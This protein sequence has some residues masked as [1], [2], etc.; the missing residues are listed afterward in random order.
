MTG[1]IL[2]CLLRVICFVLIRECFI[3]MEYQLYRVMSVI[4]TASHM[5]IHWSSTTLLHD[6]PPIYN[7]LLK[8]KKSLNFYY[9]LN[10]SMQ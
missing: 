9:F 8:E 4:V 5:L 10:D 6:C 2:N 3:G 1:D 7:S